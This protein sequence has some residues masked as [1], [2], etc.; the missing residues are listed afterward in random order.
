[1]ASGWP[2]TATEMHEYDDIVIGAGMAGLTVGSLLAHAGR[3]VLLLEAHDTPGGYAH[4][5]T[6]GRYRFC[7]Q[8]HYIF[9]CSPGQPVYEVYDRLGLSE[10][11]K[12][13]RLDP[14]GFDHVV[15]GNERV[16]IPNGLA[17]YRNQLIH[18]FPEAERALR[19]FFSVIIGMAEEIDAL[20]DAPGL[21]DIVTAP[22]RFPKSIRYRTWTLQDLYDHV[23][24]PP[25]LQAILAGQSGDYLL[26]PDQVSLGLHVALVANYD[27]GAFYPVHHYSHMVEALADTIRNGPGCDLLLN[28][29]VASIQVEGDRVRGVT[30]NDGTRYRARRCVSNVD[31]RM[32]MRMVDGPV[33]PKFREKVVYPYS[34]STVTLY[35]GIRGLD[36]RDFGFGDYNVWHYPHADINAIYR[37]QLEHDDLNDP[38]LFLS[39]PTLH[40]D[41]PG[42]APEGEQILEVATSC[43]YEYFAA[44]KQRGHKVYSKEKVRVRDRILDVLEERYIPGLRKHLAMKVAGTP[45]TN[46]HFC[47]APRGNAYG[48]NLSADAI[49]PRVPHDTPFDNLFLVNASAGYPSVGGT[50]SAGLRLADRLLAS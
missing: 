1:M 24:M 12:F 33:D 19:R 18:R 15:V 45:L 14:E 21:R 7:A 35:L 41:Q 26:P 40:S 44:L 43:S 9:G 25:L 17:K 47:R 29:E 32:T 6:M 38:W 4:T 8:V 42:L 34:T 11:V 10:Q 22:I 46:E 49:W 16:A 27:R 3:R 20:P 36:L 2:I 50:M 5:F 23:G 37:R 48:S 30:T 13:N 31:P 39:T 28:T